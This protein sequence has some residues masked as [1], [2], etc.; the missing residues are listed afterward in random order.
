MKSPSST[1]SNSSDVNI[2]DIKLKN[3][4][5]IKLLKSVGIFLGSATVLL[6]VWQLAALIYQNETLLP[7][8]LVVAQTFQGMLMNGTL[9]DHTFASLGRILLA[10]TLAAVVAIPIGVVLGTVPWLERMMRPFIEM[11]RPISPLAWIPLAI[12]WFGIGLSGKVFIIFIASFF[13]ILLNTISGVQNVN[14][15]LVR[16]AKS[17]GCSPIQMTLKVVIPAALPTITT[18][19]RIS[20]GSAWMAIIAAEMVASQS[21]LGYMIING[22]EI[23]RSDIVITGMVITGILGFIFDSVF[24]YTEK[25]MV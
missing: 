12:L 21:G 17:F 5:P 18:G 19:L 4:I 23:L 3:F 16:A 20:F 1:L 7:G 9:I 14:S 25:R 2:K 13:P 10:W 15:I 8:P 22:M 6:I 11:I 24:R